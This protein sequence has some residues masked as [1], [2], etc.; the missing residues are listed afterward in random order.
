M[1]FVFGIIYGIIGFIFVLAVFMT[2][3]TLSKKEQEQY[4]QHPFLISFLAIVTWPIY[5]LIA[6]IQ[7][8]SRKR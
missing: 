5:L 3:G 7:Y 4:L 2:I 1:G 8:L 6:I